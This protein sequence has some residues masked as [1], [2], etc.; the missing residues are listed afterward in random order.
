MCTRLKFVLTNSLMIFL[1]YTFTK[2]LETK[3]STSVRTYRNSQKVT[4]GG[5]TL[6]QAA[7]FLNLVK[8]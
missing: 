3:L 7:L 8:V 5:N 1:Y 4:G 2:L 6:Q